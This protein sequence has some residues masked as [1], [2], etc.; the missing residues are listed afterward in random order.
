LFNKFLLDMDA[1]GFGM[2][3]CCLQ[4][5]FQAQS[6]DEAKHLYDQL[7]PLTPIMLALSASSP[8]WRG[9][10]G[11]VDCR[12]N[13]I[14]AACDDR[15]LEELGKLP[16]KNDRFQINK[17]RYD[18]ISC[19][20]SEKYQKYNDIQLVRDLEIKKNLVE[21]GIDDALANHIS[22]L[23]IRDPIVVFE[24]KINIDD[25]VE[26]DHFENIQSTNWQTMRF[27]PPPSNSTIGWRV[28]FRPTEL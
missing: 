19:Y 25:E 4:M 13:V 11:D 15:T 16:L 14:S 10:L 5:T 22:H 26:T 17:S 6:I 21:N 1:M 9:Y 24:E 12:W 23:F 8:I 7:A 2:G 3:C 27:K 28:E 20:L 18:S